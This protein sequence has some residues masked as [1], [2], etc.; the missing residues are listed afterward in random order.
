MAKNINFSL[1]LKKL[2]DAVRAKHGA[3]TISAKGEQYVNITMWV[4]D[5]EYNFGNDIS[6]QLNSKSR[7]DPKVYVDNAKQPE[8][9]KGATTAPSTATKGYED[10]EQLPF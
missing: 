6:I 9:M 3:I 8:W 1:S 4:N 5:K 7:E 2:G 10:D